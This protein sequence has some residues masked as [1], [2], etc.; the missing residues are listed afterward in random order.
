MRY[1]NR[2]LV[3]LNY[4]INKFISNL[5]LLSNFSANKKKCI[6]EKYKENTNYFFCLLSLLKLYKENEVKFEKLESE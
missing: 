4:Y 1:Q 2:N 5:D 3:N 6:I